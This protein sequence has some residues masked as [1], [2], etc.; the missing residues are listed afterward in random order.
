MSCKYC[1]K[2]AV[3]RCRVCGRGFCPE[4]AKLQTVCSS[5][6]MNNSQKYSIS[7]TSVA[8][9][10]EHIREFVQKFWGEQEQLTF[11]RRFLVTELPTYTARN[12]KEIVGFVSFAEI[13]NAVI[14]V[15][16]G[17]LPEFQNAGVGRDLIKETEAEARRR[18]K[19]MLLVATSNDDL[20]ALAFYQSLGFQIYEVKP[21]VIA[22]KHGKIMRGVGG[23]PV[24]D[25]I[26]LR[27]GL[28]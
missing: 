23:L 25:E 4:H 7:R 19:Q 1:E 16:L 27:K 3:Y 12:G 20:P 21:D 2:D 8:K 11:D 10:K 18:R 15:A 28:D 26:R 24:R 6:V 17:I 22:E 13:E 14:I 5:C 9:D